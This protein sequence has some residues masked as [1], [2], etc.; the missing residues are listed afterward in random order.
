MFHCRIIYKYTRTICYW[1]FILVLSWTISSFYR[2]RIRTLSHVVCANTFCRCGHHI[3]TYII[4]YTVQDS[5]YTLHIT[6]YKYVILYSLLFHN[7]S[8]F[9]YLPFMG[10]NS[11]LFSYVYIVC[12]VI[13]ESE[14]LFIKQ[15]K[16]YRVFVYCTYKYV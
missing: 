11:I 5:S 8:S 10:K 12:S 15:N 7:K 13:N 6:R 9:V 1:G 2:P 14:T 4:L 3:D 16:I